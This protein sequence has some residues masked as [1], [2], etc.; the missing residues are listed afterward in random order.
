M[1]IVPMSQLDIEAGVNQKFLRS[2]GSN[3]IST[4]FFFFEI[5]VSWAGKGLHISWGVEIELLS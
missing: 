1:P 3:P 2:E 4:F 5:F